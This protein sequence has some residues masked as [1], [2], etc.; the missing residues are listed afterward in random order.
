[1]DEEPRDDDAP[2][3]QAMLYGSLALVA[4]LLLIFLPLYPKVAGGGF[5]WA[6]GQ[7]PSGLPARHLLAYALSWFSP[8][9]VGLA[10]VLALA[11]RKDPKVAAGALFALGATASITFV[12]RVLQVWTDVDSWRVA[13]SL[14]LTAITA[15]LLLAAGAA[16]LRAPATD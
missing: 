2:R 16:A 11:A 12:T 8:V 6:M 7:Y 13:T 10:A 4:G 5:G 15:G 3:R 9:L 14:V 1:M